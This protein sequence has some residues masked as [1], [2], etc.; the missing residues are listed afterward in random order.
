MLTL[1]DGRKELYQWDTGRAATVDIDCDIVHLEL[2][3]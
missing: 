3:E 1:N 2:E